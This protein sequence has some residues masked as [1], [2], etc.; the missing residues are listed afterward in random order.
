M[1]RTRTQ[2][3]EALTRTGR[4]LAL[5][6]ADAYSLLVCGG[7]ALSL[8]GLLDR[9]TR[10]VDVLGLVKGTEVTGVEELLPKEIMRAAEKV[11]ADLNLPHG[12][13]NDAA[14]EVQRMGLPR[15][16]L[17]RAKPHHFGPCLTIYLIGRQ[18]QVALKLYAALDSV[19]GQRHFGDLVAIEPTQREMDSAV[20]WLLDRRTSREFRGAVG[21]ICKALGFAN[22]ADLGVLS[23]RELRR[24]RRGRPSRRKQSAAQ[25]D[26]HLSGDIA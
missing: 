11:A 7:S 13:L 9:P 17:K 19:K 5:A 24:G 1:F 3:Q 20:R 16:I 8:A 15:G 22:L 2:I 6:D 4:H 14:L 26:R 21:K 10:D 23:V 12:W 25:P 18:D